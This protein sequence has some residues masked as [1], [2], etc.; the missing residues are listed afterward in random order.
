MCI[1]TRDVGVERNEKRKIYLYETS[2]EFSS[3]VCQDGG[4][5]LTNVDERQ[6]ENIEEIP[7][8]LQRIGD[9]AQRCEEGIDE[10]IDKGQDGLEIGIHDSDRRSTGK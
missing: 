7:N 8:G 2:R 6:G 1:Y 10:V 4:E 3:W 5:E 9:P